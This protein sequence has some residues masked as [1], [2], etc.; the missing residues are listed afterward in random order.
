MG[1]WVFLR[2]EE[3]LRRLPQLFFYEGRR[4]FPQFANTR[5]PMITTKA[6]KIHA[7]EFVEFDDGLSALK[8]MGEQD[9][10]YEARK[11]TLR[12]ATPD[13]AIVRTAKRL[14]DQTR[15]QPTPAE[16][17]AIGRDWLPSHHPRRRPIP[18]LRSVA[19]KL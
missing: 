18:I 15:W 3:G 1:Y 17:D 10:A 12:T 2:T 5:Q 16:I 6:G 7:A 14:H 9:T 19:T 13:L 4:A 11:R 8:E